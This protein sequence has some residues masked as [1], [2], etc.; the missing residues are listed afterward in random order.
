MLLLLTTCCPTT[1]SWQHS[2]QRVIASDDIV[3]LCIHVV[4]ETKSQCTVMCW[5]NK[6]TYVLADAPM[7]RMLS[8]HLTAGR[9]TVEDWLPWSLYPRSG[10]DVSTYWSTGNDTINLSNSRRQSSERYASV[11]LCDWKTN[12]CIFH[13]KKIKLTTVHIVLPVASSYLGATWVGSSSDPSSFSL[14]VESTMVSRGTPG[15][16][17]FWTPLEASAVFCANLTMP[18][19]LWLRCKHTHTVFYAVVTCELLVYA[20]RSSIGWPGR[21]IYFADALSFF[22]LFWHRN[23]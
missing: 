8:F 10:C 17:A 20:S 18:N 16:S 7:Q 21:P 14:D 5:L 2:P 12:L 22:L 3:I 1:C 19:R 9:S 15:G 13:V 11:E 6:R 4:H 23:L